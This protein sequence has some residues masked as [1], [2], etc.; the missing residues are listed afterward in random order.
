MSGQVATRC[1]TLYQI[2]LVE[3]TLRASVV[4]GREMDLGKKESIIIVIYDM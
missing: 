4:A 1:V 3:E 2:M